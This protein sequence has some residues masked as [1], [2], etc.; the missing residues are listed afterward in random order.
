MKLR[1]LFVLALIAMISAYHY[2]GANGFFGEFV[3]AHPI[4]FL[5]IYVVA[6]TH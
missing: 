1:Y 3:S 6:I 2:I 4:T 5:I